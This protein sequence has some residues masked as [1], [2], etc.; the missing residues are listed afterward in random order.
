MRFIEVSGG[1]L[2][3]AAAVLAAAVVLAVVQWHWL[4][5]VFGLLTF[6]SLLDPD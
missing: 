3:A 1:Y 5:L 2:A 4:P 6:F